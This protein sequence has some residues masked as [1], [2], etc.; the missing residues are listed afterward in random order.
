MTVP[1]KRKTDIEIYEGKELLDRR[2]EL[3]NKI[4]EADTYLPDAVLHDD[5]DL[6]MMEFVTDSPYSDKETKNFYEKAEELEKKESKE[7][8][9]LINENSKSWWD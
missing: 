9:K 1:K 6:G 4:T 7:L 8:Y 3:L 2:Q 5:L